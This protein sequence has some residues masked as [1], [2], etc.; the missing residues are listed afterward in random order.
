LITVVYLRV[1]YSP[2]IPRVVYSPLIPQ[3]VDNPL[4]LSCF[5]VLIILF[6]FHASGVNPPL[7]PVQ[8]GGVHKEGYSGK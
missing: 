2:L 8:R 3:G 1:V 6:L 7:N 5:P 4:P